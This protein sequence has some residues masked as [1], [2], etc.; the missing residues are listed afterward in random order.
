[1]L[2]SSR[3][4]KNNKNFSYLCS[5]MNQQTLKKEYTFEGRGLHTGHYAHLT[6]CPASENHG[7]TFLRT[8]VGV[9]IPAL[10][11]KV[12]RTDR[13]TTITE[14]EVSV[15]T[16]EHLLSA[17]T[18]LG[19]DNALIKVDND[20]VPILDGSAETYVRAIAPDGLRVQSAP[21]RY[22]EIKEEIEVRDEK[23][24]S[25]VKLTP[26]DHFSL[27][28]T[29][30]FGSKVLGVQNCSWDERSDY[31]GQ[32]APCRTFCFFHEL[33]YLASLGLVK[34]GDVD[35]AIVIVEH[36]VSEEQI[37]KMCSLFG[38]PRLSVTEQGYL[39]NI[40]LHFPN[41]WGR[42][43]MLDLIGDIRLVGG[44]PKAH[45]SAYKPGHKINST[46]AK[47]VLSNR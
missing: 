2:S 27:E 45:V 30:D 37:G 38:Q 33:E 43:K 20:E 31:V 16:I 36:P 47:A 35:N 25:W 41:E 24:G 39:S 9:E 44:Y 46:A 28:L 14:G 12:T 6:I 32:I 10:A 7:I 5:P 23:T 42:H 17:L 3:P 13:S 34:G 8:D 21:R 22:V 18:G 11:S 29:V 15:I 26:S 19:V 1:M 4:E 40:T